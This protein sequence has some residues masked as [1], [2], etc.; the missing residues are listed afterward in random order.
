MATRKDQIEKFRQDHRDMYPN[1][2][3]FLRCTREEFLAYALVRGRPY[4]MAE[5][6][7]KPYTEKSGPNEYIIA[8][9]ITSWFPVPDPVPVPVLPD[10]SPGDP[11][12]PRGYPWPELEYDKLVAQI[13][14]WITKRVPLE[15][16]KVWTDRLALLRASQLNR[17]GL[18]KWTPER[19]ALRQAGWTT[20]V[21]V[22]VGQGHV[23]KII[24]GDG[25]GPNLQV[26]MGDDPSV[27]WEALSK[28]AL[29]QS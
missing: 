15:D 19:V 1:G 22:R 16:W 18:N 20:S 27:C 13:R 3:T 2:E 10:G 8:K 11:P 12:T 28:K 14:K 7:R 24:R 26:V 4:W 23:F 25:L 21:H 5:R 6:S 29:D 9:A 17:K